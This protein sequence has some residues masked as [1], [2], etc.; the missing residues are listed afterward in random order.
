MDGIFKIGAVGP[1]RREE[2]PMGVVCQED[3]EFQIR[4]LILVAT[5]TKHIFP[6]YKAIFAV[7][8]GLGIEA[9]AVS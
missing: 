4:R 6:L 5:A 3:S 2:Q 9:P 7:G 8:F 1:S